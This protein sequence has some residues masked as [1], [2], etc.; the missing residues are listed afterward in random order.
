[1]ERSGDM[2]AQFLVWLA[3]HI[4]DRRLRGGE[5]AAELY[6]SRSLLDRLVKASA[7]EPPGR[8]LRWLLLER[9]AFQLRATGTSVIDAAVQAG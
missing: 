1:V 2:F 9:A 5:L 6:V 8:F 7:G 4:D 3:R